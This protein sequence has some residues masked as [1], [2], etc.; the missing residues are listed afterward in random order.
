MPHRSRPRQEFCSTL[1]RRPCTGLFA[2]CF[3]VAKASGDSVL[4]TYNYL[5]LVPKGRDEDWG[6]GFSG[7]PVI[8]IEDAT[9]RFTLFLVPVGRWSD[10]TPAPASEH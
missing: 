1:A 5:D 6:A 8:G 9:E 2:S 4:N 7:S 10:G 3:R